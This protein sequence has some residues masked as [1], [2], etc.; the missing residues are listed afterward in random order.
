M[1]YVNVETDLIVKCLYI[2][3]I[4]NK[5]REHDWIIQVLRLI[6]CVPDSTLAHRENFILVKKNNSR[7]GMYIEC[8]NWPNEEECI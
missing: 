4:L 1:G 6:P 8:A 5:S 3:V 2:G 7:R